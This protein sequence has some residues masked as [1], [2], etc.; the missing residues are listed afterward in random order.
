[1]NQG[2][3]TIYKASAGSGKTF[4]LALEYIKLLIADPQEYQHILAVTFT[5]DATG[6]MKER[7]LKQLNGLK[8]N[9]DSSKNFRD[10]LIKEMNVSEQTVLK[11]ASTA[12]SNIL[13]DYTH[14][15]IRTIDSFFQVIIKNLAHDLG[16]PPNQQIIIENTEVLETA[17][18]N[19]IE[20]L[21]EKSTL[22]N[23]VKDLISQRI[24]N[25]QRI[26]IAR[27]LKNFGQ[28][29]F[30]EEF[31]KHRLDINKALEDNER[32]S[33]YNTLLYK[34][35]KKLKESTDYVG[36]FNRLLEQCNLQSSDISRV[37][38]IYSFLKNVDSQKFDKISGTI[39]SYINDLKKWLKKS[40]PTGTEEAVSKILQPF[41]RKT[42][43]D[44]LVRAIKLNTV[45]LSRQHINQ[46]RLLGELSLKVHKLTSENNSF[47]LSDTPG[48]IHELV[49]KEDSPFI[50]EKTGTQLEHVMIDE[51]QDTS[52]LQWE[53]FK[54]LLDECLANGKGS[55]LVGDVKQSIYR[56]RNSDWNILNNMQKGVITLRNN[57]R[58]DSRIINFN[59]K[60]FTKIREVLSERIKEKTLNDKEFKKLEKAYDDVQQECPN[61]KPEQG[62]VNVSLFEGNAEKGRDWMLQSV[63]WQINLLHEQGVKFADITIL[64][65][66]KADI[67]EIATFL[68][69]QIPDVTIISDE[70]FQLDSSIALQA[71]IAALQLINNPVNKTSL[72]TLASIYQKD[73]LQQPFDWQQIN[74][75]TLWNILPEKFKS[76]C[77][78]Q[79]FRM[80]PLYEL[81][82]RLMAL[83]N[84]GAIDK[85]DAYLFTFFDQVTSYLQNNPSDVTNFL[86]YWN[87]N[88]CHVTAASN[89]ADGIQIK[90]I[91]KSK[92]LEF[93]TVIIPYCHWSME[94]Y[95][96]VLC[97]PI[98]P[99]SYQRNEEIPAIPLVLIDYGGKMQQSC[100]VEEYEKEQMQ[101]WVD[102]LNLL[103]VAFTRPKSNLIILGRNSV[104]SYSV[105]NLLKDALDTEM[106]EHELSSEEDGTKKN[107]VYFYEE[108]TVVKSTENEVAQSEEVQT[109][110]IRV[111]S[112]SRTIEFRESNR[113]KEFIAEQSDRKTSHN[114]YIERG[115]LL[116]KIFSS[117][118]T[119]KDVDEVLRG[120]EF[121]GV[122]GSGKMREDIYKAVTNLLKNKVVSYWFSDKWTIRNECNIL[123]WKDGKM[124]ERRPDRVMIGKDE[125]IVVDFKFGSP[126]PEYEDQIKQYMYTLNKMKYP[127]V[128]GFLWYVLEGNE[129]KQINA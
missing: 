8:R 33:T 120:L 109:P 112:Y 17:V 103:Y 81:L 64:V 55:L 29:I 43:E 99:P 23:G 73:I 4:R 105:E 58:S 78:N 9:E 71:L 127:N 61:G 94:S 122:I 66:K 83:F 129:V 47:L 3:L 106:E 62:Y 18:D 24:E 56:W 39:D 125:T 51:F 60:I 102:N 101:Q 50:F 59:N 98:N 22:L 93:H 13:H 21:D 37:N 34:E 100:Y 113:S 86:N 91:H 1:M 49:A 32:I 67:K 16:L 97:P 90:T 124:E 108:G 19:L 35:E 20:T 70:A 80:L 38:S 6:E 114:E 26:D 72:L 111:K 28:L 52:E 7:I 65:R 95:N 126:H 25:D 88:L 14:F 68:S 128:K 12:L 96:S 30:N 79:S 40:S 123:T 115:K 54:I 15:Y 75:E 119:I 76:L 85:Q 121:E 36:T 104:R 10:I 118:H 5:N 42:R 41:I 48:L 116:H 57:F 27:E 92:G 2:Q 77:H 53:N 44:N 89:A 110:N 46:M 87:E 11:Q 63:L 69:K 117:I 45:Y 84:L 31:I 82:E 74:D 107:C